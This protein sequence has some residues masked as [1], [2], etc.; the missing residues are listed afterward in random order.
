MLDRSVVAEFLKEEF[1]D[2]D[3]L[4]I[5]PEI[6]MD[7][8]VETFCQYTED[9]YFEWLKDNCKSFFN[10]NNPDW[11]RIRKRIAYYKVQ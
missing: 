5:P 1:E 8:L 11:D 2:W 9:D 10:H 7:V 4:E 6:S 3:G